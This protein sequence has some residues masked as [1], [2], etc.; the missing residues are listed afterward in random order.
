VAEQR[1][2]VVLAVISDGETVTEA[3]GLDGL[4]TARIGPGRVRIRSPRR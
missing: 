2:Q 3:D 4:P 1:Y